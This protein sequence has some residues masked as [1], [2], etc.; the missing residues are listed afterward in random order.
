MI[1]AYQHP[2]LSM[3][4]C[5]L[6]PAKGSSLNFSNLQSSTGCCPS[7]KLKYKIG[8]TVNN[9]YICS[10]QTVTHILSVSKKKS[11]GGAMYYGQL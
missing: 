10:T 3:H 1:S 4:K 9:F 5:V 6:L 2:K 11:G 8:G 7:A